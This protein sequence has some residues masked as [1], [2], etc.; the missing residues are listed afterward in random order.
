MLRYNASIWRTNV[1]ALMVLQLAWSATGRVFPNATDF[2]CH[3]PMV[4]LTSEPYHDYYMATVLEAFYRDY[5]DDMVQLDFEGIKFVLQPN[6]SLD[7]NW[8]DFVFHGVTGELCMV[9]PAFAGTRP[10]AM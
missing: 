2:D 6:F 4:V 1:A 9:M 5:G 8:G 10:R 3:T 7:S